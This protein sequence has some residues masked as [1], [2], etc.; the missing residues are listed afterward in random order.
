MKFNEINSVK[1]LRK[2]CKVSKTSL[3]LTPQTPIKYHGVN[4]LIQV[5]YS[6]STPIGYIISNNIGRIENNTP[7]ETNILYV[8][9]RDTFF[10]NTTSRYLF[11]LRKICDC[12]VRKD[13]LRIILS[14][15]GF[16]T[17]KL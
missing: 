15:L 11:T 9:N 1:D 8:L 13:T 14:D 6:Y 10:S 2:Y 4:V 3:T 7:Y 12:M 17:G 5:I 16:K